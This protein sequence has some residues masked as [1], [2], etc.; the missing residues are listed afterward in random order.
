MLLDW[1]IEVH[2]ITIFD[3]P[4]LCKVVLNDSIHGYVQHFVT[5]DRNITELSFLQQNVQKIGL[6]MLQ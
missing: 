1:P 6:V 5:F 4:N 3:S 2:I